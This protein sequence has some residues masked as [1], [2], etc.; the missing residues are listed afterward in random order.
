[1]S[2]STIQAT[3]VQIL[4]PGTSFACTDERTP[5]K[6]ESSLSRPRRRWI[7]RWYF[8]FFF[9]SFCL[10][11]FD[12][13]VVFF[14]RS[15][16]QHTCIVNDDKFVWFSFSCVIIFIFIFVVAFLLFLSLSLP[17]SLSFPFLFV[18]L[19]DLTFKCVFIAYGVWNKNE[20]KCILGGNYSSWRFSLF[21]H[22]YISC[23]CVSF[24]FVRSKNDE[25]YSQQM[26]SFL[27]KHFM[28]PSRTISDE[29]HWTI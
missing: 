7:D 3:L 25:G 19:L 17:A 10:Y 12:I 24:A 13:V 15:L 1:M 20:M 6:F 22:S 14:I 2:V 21:S 11:L 27:C 23:V 4:N 8:N 16:V 28:V 29:L 5:R 9:K 26:N 18:R